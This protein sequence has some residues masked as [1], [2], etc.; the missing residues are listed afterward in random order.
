MSHPKYVE[1]TRF[2]KDVGRAWPQNEKPNY[3]FLGISKYSTSGEIGFNVSANEVNKNHHLKYNIGTVGA[4][5]EKENVFLKL[6]GV[7]FNQ[8]K[9][10][11]FV[12]KAAVLK[13]Q[14]SLVRTKSNRANSPPPISK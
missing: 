12:T 5:E 3:P 2:Y 6:P 10:D 11:Q 1:V 13:A 4:K 9:Y 14:T 8:S 7:T